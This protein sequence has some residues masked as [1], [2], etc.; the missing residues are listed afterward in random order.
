MQNISGELP[1]KKLIEVYNKMKKF[2]IPSVEISAGGE[3]LTNFTTG[4][5]KEEI[6]DVMPYAKAVENIIFSDEKFSQ[7]EKDFKIGFTSISDEE[8]ISLIQH[9]GFV[10]R[11]IDGNKGFKVYHNGKVIKDFLPEQEFLEE[12]FGEAFSYEIESIDYLEKIERLKRFEPKETN[13]AFEAWKRVSVKETKFKDVLSLKLFVKNGTLTQED[14]KYLV[15]LL[16]D[17]DA[18]FVRTTLNKNL[19]IPLVHKSALGYIYDY[20]VKYL[21]NIV[22]DFLTVEGLINVAGDRE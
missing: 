1:I 17:L 5:E 4:I 18:P 10:A 22:S 9:M 14:I 13:F 15:L 7:S 20:L 6:F 11:E 19:F 8:Y 12:I 3:I 16:N 21:P 2:N